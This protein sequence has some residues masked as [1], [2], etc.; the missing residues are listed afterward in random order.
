MLGVQISWRLSYIQ[1]DSLAREGPI[2]GAPIAA[3]VA[4]LRL[5]AQPG[6]LAEVAP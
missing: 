5:A 1:A 6:V 3:Q 2:G 4:P